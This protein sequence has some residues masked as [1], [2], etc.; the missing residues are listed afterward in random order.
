LKSLLDRLSGVVENPNRGWYTSCVP[1]WHGPVPRIVWAAVVVAALMQAGAASSEISVEPP[2]R[3]GGTLRVNVTGTDFRSLDPALNFDSDGAQIL[4]ATC[5]KLL[6]HP[7]RRAPA[8]SELEPDVADSMPTVSPDARTYTFQVSRGFTFSNGRPLRASDFAYTIRRDLDPRMHSPAADFLRDVA[9]YSAHGDTF[10]VTLKRPAPDF[11]ARLAMP[12]F[13]A[14]PRGTPISR[15]GI[16][17]IPSAG[18]Y[19]VASRTPGLSVILKRNPYYKG[20][21]PHHLDEM[22]FSVFADQTR[23]IREIEAGRADYDMHGVQPQLRREVALRY[24]VHG[25]RLL[26]ALTD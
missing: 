2:I 12:F 13:C 23:S 24:G 10:T 9:S 19:Y 8:G 11:L 15:R 17:T 21:R 18:P 14:V 16:D 22:D 20:P 26:E 25:S 7:D 1:P 4:Y 6:N 3:E 5:A